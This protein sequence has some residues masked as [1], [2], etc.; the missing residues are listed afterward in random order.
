MPTARTESTKGTP[1]K[2]CS[3]S[4]DLKA[5]KIKRA[6]RISN[7]KSMNIPPRMSKELRKKMISQ[8]LTGE[9]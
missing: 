6:S 3:H 9:K 8:R 4:Q 7:P 2:A 1:C 5:G